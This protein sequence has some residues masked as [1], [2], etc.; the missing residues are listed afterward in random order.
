MVV[1]STSPALDILNTML[2]CA[3]KEVRLGHKLVCWLLGN[4]RILGLR[5]L[6]MCLHFSDVQM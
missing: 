2:T 3:M 4:V 6:R 1:V 5:E